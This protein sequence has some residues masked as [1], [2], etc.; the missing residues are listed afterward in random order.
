MLHRGL[1]AFCHKSI[2][3][4][5]VEGVV[6]RAKKIKI[7]HGLDPSVELGPLVSK[8]QHTKVAGDIQ[9]GRR[10]GVEVAT[11]GGVI[12]TKAISSSC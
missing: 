7:G 2:Y 3:D 6:A 11:G 8:E 10:E 1:T 4:T 5:V 9:S 12:G